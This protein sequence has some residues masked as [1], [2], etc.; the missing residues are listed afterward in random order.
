VGRTPHTVISYKQTTRMTR[1][2]TCAYATPAFHF[3]NYTLMRKRSTYV[4]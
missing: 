3:S 4:T 2:E 1:M